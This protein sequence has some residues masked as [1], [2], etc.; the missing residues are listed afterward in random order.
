MI[1]AS[2]AKHLT[3]HSLCGF[4]DVTTRRSPF[5]EKS[6]TCYCRQMWTAK[7]KSVRESPGKA[8]IKTCKGDMLLKQPTIAYAEVF[9]NKVLQNTLDGL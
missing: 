8:R 2:L 7:I 4:F 9:T 5:F 3:E 1:K 6:N